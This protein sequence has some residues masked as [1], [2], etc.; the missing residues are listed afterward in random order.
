MTSETDY[1][2]V[3][4]H[5]VSSDVPLGGTHR[6]RRRV[7]LIARTFTLNATDPVQE[8]LPQ[9]DSRVWAHVI[10]VTNAVLTGT[11][12][13]D[14]LA[15]AAAGTGGAGSVPAAMKWP[16]PTTDQVWAG[17]A[18]LPTTVSVWAYYEQPD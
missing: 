2:P 4:T 15:A 1:P 6:K 12:K 16:L 14:V 10:S 5:I 3:R 17:S 18:T 13:A 7:S 8:L 11:S 9:S